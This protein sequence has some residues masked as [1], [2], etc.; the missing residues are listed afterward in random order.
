ME[1]QQFLT[2]FE[3]PSGAYAV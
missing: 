1:E 3:M 2:W